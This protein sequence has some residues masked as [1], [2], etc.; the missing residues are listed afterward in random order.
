MAM[1]GRK[2]H[3]QTGRAGLLV[4]GRLD[5]QILRPPIEIGNRHDQQMSVIGLTN[6]PV[7]RPGPAEA[8]AGVLV[9]KLTLL[10]NNALQSHAKTLLF[11][12]M[13]L[14]APAA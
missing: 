14:A 3:R 5:G 11:I 12:L 7:Q 13:M 10:S 4:S 6:F 9:I 2:P 1:P 8:W